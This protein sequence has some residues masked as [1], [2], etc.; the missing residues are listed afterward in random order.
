MTD[1]YERELDHALSEKGVFGGMTGLVT[2][3][4]F[5]SLRFQ[6]GTRFSTSLTLSYADFFRSLDSQKMFDYTI[7]RSSKEF[8]FNR[9]LSLRAIA[10]YNFFRRQ[11]TTDILAA[12]TYIPGTVIYLGYGGNYE[13]VRFQE[14]EYVPGQRL[15]ETERGFFFKASFL[16]RL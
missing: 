10:E 5:A 4:A 9:Y 13:K 16:W 15:I 3:G 11:L 12:F 6:P 8:Q 7:L 14:G 1:E 2:L